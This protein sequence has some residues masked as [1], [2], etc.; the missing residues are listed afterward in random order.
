MISALRKQ[1]VREADIARNLQRHRSTICRELQR[2][3]ARY[4][5]AYRPSIA[6]ERTNG[7][8]SR[9]RR[10][11]RFSP[12]DWLRIE[13]LLR[14]DWSPEQIAGRLRLEGSLSISHETIYRH[15]RQDR[16]RG[17]LLFTH[18][19]FS[20]KQ[21]RKRYGRPDSRGRLRGKRM[22]DE[23]P[24]EIEQRSKIGHWEGDTVMGRATTR[25][26]ILTLLERKAG[27]VLIGKLAARTTAQANQR[28]ECLMARNP[29]CFL[30]ITVDN[31]TEFHDY[32]AVERATGVKFYFAHPYHSWERGSN[33]N[34]NG[35]IRQYV[36]KG[37]SM[38]GLSQH[39]CEFISTR[40][41]NRPRKRHGFRT[42]AEVFYAE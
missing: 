7:R 11:S 26:C 8:R 33:E 42:P 29:N 17:G 27:V 25:E 3:C 18:L 31:G 21:K 1:G 38:V 36:P 20:R 22:I 37:A 15:V 24:P 41:N 9:S 10:N 6:V 23:R 14:L 19:R 32:E 35:L 30:S 4:D 28:I 16:R 5:G 2:N 13:Q 39:R 12:S 34:V 40:L